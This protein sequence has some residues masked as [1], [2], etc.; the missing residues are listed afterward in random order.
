VFADGL[1]A[2][3]NG[4]IKGCGRQFIIM[5]IVVIAYWVVGL[6]LSY[7]F[8]FVQNEGMM[9]C[10]NNS[11]FCGD[12]GLV[13]GYVLHF[14]C[15]FAFSC[16]WHF[17]DNESVLCISHVWFFVIVVNCLVSP[18]TL[19]FGRDDGLYG[20]GMAILY[21]TIRVPFPMMMHK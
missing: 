4:I 9:E 15:R 2:A 21:K 1:Q 16:R 10:N 20:L 8:A 17:S 14:L 11:Y 12:V 6:P 7:Y 5:P 13:A 19:I 18:R 3:F